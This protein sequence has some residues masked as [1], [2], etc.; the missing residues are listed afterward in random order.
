MRG[1]AA[2]PIPFPSPAFRA[3]NAA[4]THLRPVR[5]N[6]ATR[7]WPWSG[8]DQRGGVLEP[9]G[10]LFS[11]AK[12]ALSFQPVSAF[13]SL[14]LSPHPFPISCFYAVWPGTEPCPLR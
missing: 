13:V 7:F 5:G 8:G 14:F 9:S 2:A 6:E 11:G 12:R 10:Y 3:L 1:A 4:Q